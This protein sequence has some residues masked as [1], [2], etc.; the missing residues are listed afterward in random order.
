MGT[1]LVSTTSRAIARLL[2]SLLASSATSTTTRAVHDAPPALVLM[3]VMMP[4]LDGFEACWAIKQDPRTRLTPVV[5]VTSLGDT[6]SR[7]RGIEVGADDF[8]SRPFDAPELRARIRSLLRI[9]RYIDDLDNAESVIVSL[10]LTIEARDATTD[11][12]CQR[13][14]QYAT[15]LG[16]SLELDAADDRRREPSRLQESTGHHPR[17]LRN[18]ARRSRGRRAAAR[19]SRGNPQSGHGRARPARAPV[20]RPGRHAAMAAVSVSGG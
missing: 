5:L 10:G 7:I 2:E 19:R 14:A 18:P 13:L 16:Q 15:A 4:H 1:V 9:K 20:S 3:D 11:G 12:H 6:A 8:V 17:I